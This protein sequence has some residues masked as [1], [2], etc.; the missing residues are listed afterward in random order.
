MAR[1][2]VEDVIDKTESPFQAVLIAAKRAHQLMMDPEDALLPWDNDKPTVM[3][4]REIAEGMLDR[5]ILRANVVV[6]HEKRKALQ[7]EQAQHMPEPAANLPYEGF[8]TT[9]FSTLDDQIKKA[10]QQRD[11]DNEGRGGSGTPFL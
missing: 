3:A 6:G 11:R 7:A 5:E 8:V 10:N 1:V 9:G 2:T 4:L